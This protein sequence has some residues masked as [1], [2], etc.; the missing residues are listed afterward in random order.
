MSEIIDL[1]RSSKNV[2]IKCPSC[3]ETINSN[4]VILFDIREKYPAK[5]RNILTS[6][7]NYQTSLKKRLETKITKIKN[8]I[9]TIKAEQRMLKEKIRTKPKRIK[10]IT[11]AINMGQ[12]IEAILPANKNFQY[13]VRD[14]RTIYKPIDYIA[15]NGLTKNKKVQSIS[16]IEVKSGNATLQSNQKNIKSKIE[17]GHIKYLEY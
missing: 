8:Q 17:Q 10:T 12:I 14:C 13:D 3:G 11:T 15:F 4:Q 1:F 9:D 6:A 5:I 7:I 2:L 16:V